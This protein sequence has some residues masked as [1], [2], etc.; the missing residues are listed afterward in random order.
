MSWGFEADVGGSDND[1]KGRLD[2]P[3]TADE[4]DAVGVGKP[5]IEYG[6]VRRLLLGQPNRFGTGC[7]ERSGVPGGK[8]PLVAQANSRLVLDEENP[9]AR[10]GVSHPPQY[11]P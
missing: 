3:K 7:R 8:V 1:G 2:F 11:S 9:P 10:G 5:H 6:N 4:L